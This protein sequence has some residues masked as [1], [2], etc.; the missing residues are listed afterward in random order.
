M[1]ALAASLAWLPSQALA[2]STD[3]PANVCATGATVAPGYV[4]NT[5]G[6]G[7]P[8]NQIAFTDPATRWGEGMYIANPSGPPAVLKINPN[9]TVAPFTVD[10]MVPPAGFGVA[11]AEGGTLPNSMFISA[12][13]AGSIGSGGIYQQTLAGAGSV[14]RLPSFPDNDLAHFKLAELKNGVSGDTLSAVTVYMCG[15][16]CAA[17]D[18]FDYDASANLLGAYGISVAGIGAPA[19]PNHAESPAG[20]GFPDRV[21]GAN[22]DGLASSSAY[23]AGSLLSTTLPSTY[24]SLNAYVDTAFGGGVVGFGNDDYVLALAMNESGDTIGTRVYRVNPFGV[25]Q[26]IVTVPVG[27]AISY[28]IERSGGLAFGR[29]GNFGKDLYFSAGDLI[30]RLSAPD[31][32]GDGVLDSVDNCP[33][34]ANPSQLN[35]DGDARGD[36]CDLFPTNP[37]CNIVPGT[38]A[39]DAGMA[40]PW[41]APLAAISLLRGLRRGRARRAD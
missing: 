23:F 31:Q 37:N 38:D 2:E 36:A 7:L 27:D 15:G 34:V 33:T 41:L 39:R 14:F 5:L 4:L 18:V 22:V 35:T 20:S 12:G 25:A 10:P 30:C 40:W 19:L 13:I 11:V 9:G 8:T 29:G 24:S 32:D 1:S 21:Y 17:L 28:F 6:V 16:L 3:G 26:L